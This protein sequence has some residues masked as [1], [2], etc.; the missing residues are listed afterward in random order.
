[1]LLVAAAALAFR[2][3]SSVPG[4]VIVVREG[5]R[6]CADARVLAGRVDIDL[7]ALTGESVPV[8]RRA[9]PARGGG[10]A[11]EATDLIFSD[12]TCTNGEA[13]A[14]VFDTGM[15]TQLGRVAALSS[16][17]ETAASLLQAEVKRVAWLI[18][19]I[20]VAAGA[21]FVPLGTLAAGLPI[22][23]AVVF[24]IGPR[25]SARRR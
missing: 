8:S 21:A 6:I 14:V 5:E 4:D 23:D 11:L 20:A 19:A 12:S 9:G 13:H 15:R 24:A 1:L 7:S 25:R 10:P 17:I 2:A 16:G 18:A 3:G 22:D